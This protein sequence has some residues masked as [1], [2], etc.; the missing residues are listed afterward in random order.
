MSEAAVRALADGFARGLQRHLMAEH[1]DLSWKVT[2][3]PIDGA[4]LRRLED[5]EEG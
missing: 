5:R 3:E 1:P 2:V 4:E